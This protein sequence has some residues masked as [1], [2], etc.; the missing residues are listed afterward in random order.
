MVFI[1]S[2]HK[3]LSWFKRTFVRKVKRQ[4]NS[5]LLKDLENIE[6]RRAFFFAD[7]NIVRVSALSLVE[8]SGFNAN[9][10]VPALP[11]HDL[12]FDDPLGKLRCL[13]SDF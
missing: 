10:P 2:V 5:Q 11:F 4:T 8:F 6:V 9:V 7:M 13:N 12:P 1:F 3:M